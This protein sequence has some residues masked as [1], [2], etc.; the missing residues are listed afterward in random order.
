M[1][2]DVG[3]VPGKVKKISLNVPAT[4]YDAVE[5]ASGPCG[6]TFSR[7]PYEG[8]DGNEMVDV[9]YLNGRELATRKNNGK[10]IKEVLW[11][12]P[13]KDGDIVLLIPK[14]RGNQF[15][16]KIARV[17]GEQHSIAL[18][19]ASDKEAKNKDGTV[20][21]AIQVAGLA[22]LAEDEMVMVNGEAVQLDHELKDGDDIRIVKNPNPKPVAVAVTETQPAGEFTTVF[23]NGSFEVK[24][25]KDEKQVV[26]QILK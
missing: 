22:L 17:P 14:I 5:A 25:S 12:T 26:F 11:D 16:V 3:R 7:E 19:H 10:Y 1:N 2:L 23:G 6:F 21:N 24:V 20:A 15:I 18:L 4:V 13:V 9:P 8:P